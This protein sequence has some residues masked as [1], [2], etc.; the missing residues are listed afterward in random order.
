M[1]EDQSMTEKRDKPFKNGRRAPEQERVE[2]VHSWT[3]TPALNSAFD[4]ATPGDVVRSLLGKPP[5]CHTEKVEADE[6]SVNL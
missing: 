6:P 4:G 2:A 3:D 5:V 1:P